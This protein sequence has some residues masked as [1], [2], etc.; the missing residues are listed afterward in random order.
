MLLRASLVGLA[1]LHS[2]ATSSPVEKVV[3]LLTDLKKGIEEDGGAEQQVYD[4]FACW[5]EKTTGRKAGAIVDANNQIRSLGQ[6]ILSLKGKVAT[7]GSEIEELSAGIKKNEAAQEE[8]TNVR[9]RENSDFMAESA[10]QKQAI[11]ALQSAIKTLVA[12]TNPIAKDASLLQSSASQTAVKKA[13]AALPSTVGLS[14]KQMALLSEVAAGRYAPQSVTVQGML[15]D[16]YNTFTADL[17]GATQSEAMANRDFE[18]FTATKSAEL[19]EMRE[20]REKKEGEKAEAEALLADT[21]QEYDDTEAQKNAD[22]EFFDETKELCMKKAKEW[23][24]R[25]EM[26][27]AELEG[28]KKGLEILTSDDARELFAKSIKPGKE[29]K[30]SDKDSGVDIE[31]FLQ[32][33]SDDSVGAPQ[34]AYA[35]LKAAATKTQSLRLAQLAADARMAK[36][37]HFDEVINAID[38]ILTVLKEEEA[39]DIAKRDECK[40]KFHEIES[41]VADLTW[42]ISVNDANMNK[43]QKQIEKRT[44]EKEDTIASIEDVNDQ[45]KRLEDQRKEENDAFK[46]SKSDDTAAIEL[47]K[48]ARGAI[49]KYYKEN[50]IEMLQKPFAVSEDQAPDADFTGAESRKTET[51]GIL[52]LMTM[53]IEDLNDEIKNGMD[54]EEEAQLEFE[55]MVKAAKKLKEELISKKVSLEDIIAKRGEQKTSESEKKDNNNEDKTSEVDYKKEIKPD[56]DFILGA[57]ENRALKRSAERDGLT[58]AKSI[59][60]G[61]KPSLLERPFDDRAFSKIRFLSVN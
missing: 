21:T 32:V 12:A 49:S 58:Q 16:M 4:K 34:H 40:D 22:V 7:L 51:K 43:L 23:T 39:A 15:A 19:R 56:C 20:T 53:L 37:G 41:T 9:T 42:K 54:G 2:S 24:N 29:T 47:L 52:S 13:I 59:L 17:E 33:S 8:A 46:Q 25:K 14:R 5:C 35:V 1:A 6:Q 48:A 55:K 30:S 31:S 38:E 11:A 18:Q 61:A 36:S 26:R 27:D 44:E 57:F 10:E 28:I 50:K 3:Q 45:I 60:A